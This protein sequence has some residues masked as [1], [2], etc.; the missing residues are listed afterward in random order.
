MGWV[1]FSKAR[2]SALQLFLHG[3]EQHIRLL[4]WRGRSPTRNSGEQ[5]K[6]E[7][8]EEEAGAEMTCRHVELG[9]LKREA[10][11]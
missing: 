4:A 7:E 9:L 6:G 10:T 5:C 2:L 3:R 11:R 1:E 8:Y